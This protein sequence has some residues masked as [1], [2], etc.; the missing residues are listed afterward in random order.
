MEKE[1]G[2]T[3][4]RKEFSTIVEEV[5]HRG[6]SY[7]ISRHGKPAAAVVSLRVY[8]HWKSRRRKLFDT[9]CSGQ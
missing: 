3:E 7:I 6:D 1:V 2:I 8:Q 4:A 9:I 5:Q